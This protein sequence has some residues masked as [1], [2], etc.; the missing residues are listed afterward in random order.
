MTASKKIRVYDSLLFIRDPDV[1]NIPE[2]DGLKLT[3]ANPDCVAV[4]CQSDSLGE[5]VVKLGRP[6]EDKMRQVLVFD[7]EINTPSRRVVVED[8][9]VERIFSLPVSSVRTRIRVWTEGAQDSEIV[10]IDAE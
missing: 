1:E 9:H 4:S 6:A 5:T 2:I 3:W 8:I 10:V 7:G